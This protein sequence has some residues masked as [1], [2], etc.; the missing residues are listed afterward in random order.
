MLRPAA[1]APFERSV[2]ASGVQGGSK[3]GPLKQKLCFWAERKNFA[4]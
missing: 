2:V 4:Y 1:S 3:S